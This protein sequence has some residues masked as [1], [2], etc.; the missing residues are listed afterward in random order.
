M[1]PYADASLA[2]LAKA[3]G[4]RGETLTSLLKVSNFRKCHEFLLQVYEAFYRYFL[5]LYST[6][7]V[8]MDNCDKEI[9]ALI[10]G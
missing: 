1:K 2:S 8:G 6:N 5:S 10:S 9:H 7:N 3:S 4:H